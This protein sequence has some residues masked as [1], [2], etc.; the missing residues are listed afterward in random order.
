MAWKGLTFLVL[1]TRPK[2][3]GL[4]QNDYRM[5]SIDFLS[6]LSFANFFMI[7][8]KEKKKS[9]RQ[10]LPA[11]FFPQKFTLLF[12]PRFQPLKKITKYFYK[13]QY[14]TKKGPSREFIL[15]PF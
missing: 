9:F 3:G 13:N 8:Q 6:V 10:K 5:C 12:Q 11:K 14:T 1:T 15:P 4:R 2:M 7:R